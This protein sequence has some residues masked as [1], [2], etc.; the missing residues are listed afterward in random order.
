MK[1]THAFPKTHTGAFMM[2][3]RRERLAR[4]AAAQAIA[5]RDPAVQ[6]CQAERERRKGRAVPRA[7]REAKQEFQ[8]YLGA[9]ARERSRDGRA[10]MALA[11]RRAKNR[12]QATERQ[13][14]LDRLD[15]QA[16]DSRARG[17]G[18]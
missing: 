8:E 1:G 11:A 4:K 18:V 10:K 9:Q 15:F 17:F 16:I 6:L 12:P 3:G 7:L 2:E 13:I 14:I 5:A